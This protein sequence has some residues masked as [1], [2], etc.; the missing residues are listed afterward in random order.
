[1]TQSNQVPI[2]AHRDESAPILAD[3]WRLA[4]IAYARGVTVLIG[5]LLLAV[6]G[7]A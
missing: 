5:F 6:L 3:R 4:I 1:V 2:A 7:L